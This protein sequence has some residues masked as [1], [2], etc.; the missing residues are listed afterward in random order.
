MILEKLSEFR[1]RNAHSICLMGII[2]TEAL[3]NQAMVANFVDSML[4]GAS[5][6]AAERWHELI[7]ALREFKK[8]GIAHNVDYVIPFRDLLRLP[9]R[10]P[11]YHGFSG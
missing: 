1:Q 9:R 2:P 3:P 5:P 6:T 7:E 4:G 10:E 8:R 11:P